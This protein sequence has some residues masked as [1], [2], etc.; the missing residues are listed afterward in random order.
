M[1]YGSTDSDIYRV[2]KLCST[3]DN[4]I[5]VIESSKPTFLAPITKFHSAL[6][7]NYLSHD[8]VVVLYP[9]STFE[10]ERILQFRNENTLESYNDPNH[11]PIAGAV[12]GDMKEDYVNNYKA[13]GFT[14]YSRPADVLRPCGAACPAIRRTISTQGDPWALLV[15]MDNIALCS[16]IAELL[17]S[18]PVVAPASPTISEGH[19][20]P[21]GGEVSLP[22]TS[23]SDANTQSDSYPHHIS[24]PSSY[25]TDFSEAFSSL[26]IDSTHD[27][28]LTSHTRT[29]SALR[30]CRRPMLA[31]AT[32]ILQTPPHVDQV[33]GARTKRRNRGRCH[34]PFCLSR[35]TQY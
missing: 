15:N 26:S 32:W 18:D 28:P 16:P 27:C 20:I 14:L 12:P 1:C 25:V 7:M 19:A 2:Y 22:A 3:K 31:A 17:P 33:Q 10:L 29:G 9:K 34:N 8:S 11:Q 35:T 23:P 21:A 5:D 6:V 4:Y 13:R 30:E 24:W